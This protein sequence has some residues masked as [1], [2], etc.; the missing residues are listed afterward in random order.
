MTKLDKGRA[1]S[2]NIGSMLSEG[3]LDGNES[4]DKVA[5]VSPSGVLIRDID[6]PAGMAKTSATK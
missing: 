1:D 6:T 3:K 2:S 5:L 4:S